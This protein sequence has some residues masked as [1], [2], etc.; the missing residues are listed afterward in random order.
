MNTYRTYRCQWCV[1]IKAETPEEAARKAEELM[2]GALP[3]YWTVI[4]EHG[5]EQNFEVPPLGRLPARCVREH[6]SD[7]V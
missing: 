4:D 3:S 2:R 6:D 5:D 7:D 1:N